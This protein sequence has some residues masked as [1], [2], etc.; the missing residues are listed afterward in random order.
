MTDPK[1]PGRSLDW[2]TASDF[3]RFIEF[4][5]LITDKSINKLGNFSLSSD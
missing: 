4:Y 5:I 3:E 2:H 1:I